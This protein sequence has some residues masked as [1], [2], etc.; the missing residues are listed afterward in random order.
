MSVF[1]SQ[2]IILPPPGT[3]PLPPLKHSVR[4]LVFQH[5]LPEVPKKGAL[6]RVTFWTLWGPNLGR[7]SV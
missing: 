1:G 6:F 5:P 7:L 3:P 2:L 4:E